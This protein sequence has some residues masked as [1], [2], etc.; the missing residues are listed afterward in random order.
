MP[1]MMYFMNKIRNFL[2]VK[3]GTTNTQNI[4]KIKLYESTGKKFNLLHTKAGIMRA[5]NG[6]L[7]K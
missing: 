7:M 2:C 4:I 3:L 6:L 5:P 1:K